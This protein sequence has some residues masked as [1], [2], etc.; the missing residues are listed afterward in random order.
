MAKNKRKR[1]KVIDLGAFNFMSAEDG[2]EQFDPSTEESASSIVTVA[3]D[4][5]DRLPPDIIE[6]KLREGTI[7]KVDAGFR[8]SNKKEDLSLERLHQFYFDARVKEYIRTVNGGRYIKFE[9]GRML[10]GYDVDTD[11]NGENEIIKKL[12]YAEIS[13]KSF[14]N[15]MNLTMR[16]VNYFITYFDPDDEL[17]R[18]CFMIMLQLHLNQV[19][20]NPEQFIDMLYSNLATESMIRKVVRMVEYNTDESLIKTSD[21]SYD[22]SIQLTV[23]HLKAIMGISCF[24]RFLIPL[25]SHYYVIRKDEV[26]AARLT[27]KKLYAMIFRSFTGLFDKVYHINLYEK[28]YHTATTRVSKTENS[29]APMWL[30]RA[31]FGQTPASF[32]SELMDDYLID[33]SQKVVFNQSAIVFIHVCFDKSIKNELVQPDKYEMSD[34]RM[35]A[36]DSVNE[37]ISRFDRWQMDRTSYSERDRLRAYTSIRD[38]VTRLGAE[39]GLRFYLIPDQ[40]DLAKVS[41]DPE[42]QAEY[43]FYLKHTPRPF[44]DTQLYL[45]QL[46]CAKELKSAADVKMIEYEDLIKMIMIMKRDLRKR[47]YSNLPFFISSELIPTGYKGYTRRKVDK[48]YTSNP[49]YKDWVEQFPD[50]IDQ[51]N[52]EKFYN[53]LKVVILSPYRIVEYKSELNDVVVTPT[54]LVIVDEWCRFMCEL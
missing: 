39:Q 52:M 46:Y 35:E 11:E 31:R 17:M 27:D 26:D 34:M 49:M 21:N 41:P 36:S 37:T 32:V 10:Q 1:R 45:I 50:T 51:L 9:F 3:V 47:N 48:L 23:E 18:A 29:D 22:E 13:K 2:E 54:E 40:H 20:I 25:V 14:I 33:I 30:R 44:S 8:T 5:N 28:L 12:S 24:H 19:N 16:Y 15:N 43:E 42:T 7:P 38:M 6:R 4:E 53:E